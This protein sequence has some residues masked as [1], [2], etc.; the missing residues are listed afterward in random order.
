LTRLGKVLASSVVR[1]TAQGESHGGLYLLDLD[2]GASDLKLDWNSTDVDIAGRGGD[3]GLR[4]IAFHEQHILVAANAEILLL[5]QD[6]RRVGALTSAYLQHCHEISVLGSR[7]FVTSTGFDSLLVADL[8]TRRFVDGFHLAL[9]GNGMRLRHYDPQTSIGPTPSRQFHLNSVKA[10]ADGVFFSGTRLQALL[11]LRG[12]GIGQV[13]R[14]PAGTH[15]A[16]PLADGLIYNDTAADRICFRAD[17]DTQLQM[18]VPTFEHSAILNIDRYESSIARP[19]FARGLCSIDSG[20]VAGGC[21]P[22]TI[23]VYDLASGLRSLT[24]NLSMDV[25]NAIHGLARWPF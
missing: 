4:G 10:T 19:A 2:S 8:V 16:Q 3:R 22:S 21:S 1:G 13:A 7:L 18:S 15:N 25:R 14:I 24:H 5:D 20:I 9:E 12:S 11:R 17:A 6:F 23:S